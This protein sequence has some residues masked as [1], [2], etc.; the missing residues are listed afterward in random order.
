MMSEY[1]QKGRAETQVQWKY[2]G[3]MQNIIRKADS[4]VVEN[5]CP[6]DLSGKGH[7]S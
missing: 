5:A 7:D 4:L 6:L 2:L 3:L 1:L